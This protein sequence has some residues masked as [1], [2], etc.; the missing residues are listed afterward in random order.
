[1][2]TFNGVFIFIPEV[3]VRFD[4]QKPTQKQTILNFTALMGLLETN[5]KTL[6]FDYH[7]DLSM[8]QDANE[9]STLRSIK[10]HLWIF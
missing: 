7:T 8:L 2:T 10:S 5:F 9:D 6:K 3:L 4:F 1:M